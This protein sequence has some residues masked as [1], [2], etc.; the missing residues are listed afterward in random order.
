V[1][2]DAIAVA[3]DRIR[4]GLERAILAGGA[5]EYDPLVHASTHAAGLVGAVAEAG[6]AATHPRPIAEGAAVVLLEA[7][8]PAVERGAARRAVVAG[9]ARA[10]SIRG[11]PRI[12]AIRRA[13][14]AACA[15]ADVPMSRLDLVVSGAA[16]GP[17]AAA[18]WT[19]R[20]DLLEASGG[21]GLLTAPKGF[22]GEGFGY[23]SS[24]LV[25]LGALALERGVVPPSVASDVEALPGSIAARMT[26]RP[27]TRPMSHVLIIVTTQPGGVTALVLRRSPDATERV[28]PIDAS[29]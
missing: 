12:D 25:V 9:L 5:E 11:R 23:T 28:R 26:I 3:A 4:F 19:A 14:A 10:R 27:E 2:L 29:V 17:F 21:P 20:G 13:A 18:E 8:R 22:L 24:A 16:G 15:E 1:G 7:E 6:A